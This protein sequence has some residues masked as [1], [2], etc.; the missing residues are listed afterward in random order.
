[1]ARLSKRSVVLLGENHDNAEHHRWQLQMLAALH[2]H[3]PDMVVGFEMFPRRVQPALDRWAAGALDTQTFLKNSD[4]QTVWGFKPELYLPLFHFV[5]QNRLGMIGLNVERALISRVGREGWATI[6]QRERQGVSTPAPASDGYKRYLADI[7]FQSHG[8]SKTKGSKANKTTPKK[9]T[10]EAA[11]K[12]DRFKRFVAAQITWDRAMAEAL[13]T[14]YRKRPGSLVVGVM[15]Q[16]HTRFGYGV[17]HQLAS[18][19]IA[20]TAIVLPVEPDTACK[21]LPKGIADAVFVVAPQQSIQSRVSKPRLGIRLRNTLK[22]VLI[23]QIIKGSVAEKAKLA[24]GD[25]VV[26]AAGQPLKKYSELIAIIGR[27]SPGTW[28]PLL[29]RRN[30]KEIERVA[31]FPPPGAAKEK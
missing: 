15:G 25:I 9:P 2:A 17:P 29:I 12:N 28:L 19:G 27:Q 26:S 16:G 18:L 8:Q 22:G 30:G 5:R 11:M 7:F 4:W 23:S 10:L 31:K 21:D 6:P 20:D 14:A 1:M 3:Q 13:G 24:K